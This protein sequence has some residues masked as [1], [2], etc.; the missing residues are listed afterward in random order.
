MTLRLRVGRT[1][2]LCVAQRYALHSAADSSTESVAQRCKAVTRRHD[3]AQ[4]DCDSRSDS[5]NVTIGEQQ[6]CLVLR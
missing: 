6:L 3:V 5:N 4:C 2:W 1:L